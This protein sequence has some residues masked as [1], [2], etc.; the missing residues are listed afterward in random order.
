MARH[1]FLDTFGLGGERE[2]WATQFALTA[3]LAIET[4]REEK[5]RD[6]L[7]WREELLDAMFRDDSPVD[8]YHII[9]DQFNEADRLAHRID[10]LHHR[11]CYLLCCVPS[12]DVR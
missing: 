10:G 1:R 6:L 5:W 4:A 8:P 12:I 3:Q 2:D 11:V 9:N 7:A